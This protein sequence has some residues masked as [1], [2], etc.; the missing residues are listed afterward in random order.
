MDLGLKGK[1]ALVTGSSSGLGLAIARELAQEGA[2]V[3]MVARR[4][5]ELERQAADISATTPGRAI[6]IVADLRER[7]A[8]TRVAAEAERALGPVD[9]LLANAGGPPSTVFATT[10]EEQYAPRSSST[11]WRRSAWRR[12]A[13]PACGSGSGAGSSSS[14]PWRPSSRSGAA[15]LQH[16]SQRP[17][18]LRQDPGGRGR[19]GQRA[20]QHGTARPLR[21]RP[22]GRARASARERESRKIEEILGERLSRHPGR[23][24]GRAARARGS[25]R[26]PRVLPGHLPDGAAIQVDG[27]QIGSLV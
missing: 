20:R 10:G 15:A 21:H 25:R 1:V 9:I 5:D 13:C 4:R 16:R 18:G 19:P 2:A 11:S 23:S 6:P 22:Y 8:P 27:G 17:A 26:I 14:P 12:H 24:R 3:A 7:D